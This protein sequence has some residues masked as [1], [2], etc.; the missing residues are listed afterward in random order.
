[1]KVKLSSE[2]DVCGLGSCQTDNRGVRRQPPSPLSSPSLRCSPPR[3]VVTH[4]LSYAIDSGLA[5][6]RK[7]QACPAEY[8]IGKPGSSL[9]RRSHFLAWRGGHGSSRTGDPPITP[10]KRP[11]ES[12]SSSAA[13]ATP[14]PAIAWQAVS[15]STRLQPSKPTRGATSLGSPLQ[16]RLTGPSASRITRATS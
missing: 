10:Q 9:V 12:L 3:P 4:G 8:S 16:A 13:G 2:L 7:A 6:C 14:L 1:M 5:R 11:A 15:W